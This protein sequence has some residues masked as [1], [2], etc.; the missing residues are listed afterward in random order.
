MCFKFLIVS[1]NWFFKTDYAKITL[2]LYHLPIFLKNEVTEKIKG[3]KK[4][5]Y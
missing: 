3:F 1:I 5:V 4:E 2:L